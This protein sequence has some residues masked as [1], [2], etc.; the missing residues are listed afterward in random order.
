MESNVTAVNLVRSKARDGNKGC[1][2]QAIAPEMGIPMAMM[3]LLARLAAK[4][5]RDE[6]LPG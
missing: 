5:F 6:K 2:Q 3:P 4:H 1:R